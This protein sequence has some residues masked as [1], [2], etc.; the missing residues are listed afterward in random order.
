MCSSFTPDCDYDNSTTILNGDVFCTNTE[1]SC[2]LCPHKK[3]FNLS[4]EA[5]IKIRIARLCA[6]CA[7]F[8]LNIKQILFFLSSGPGVYFFEECPTSKKDV[9]EDVYCP[10]KYCFNREKCESLDNYVKTPTSIYACGKC[11]HWLFVH[12]VPRMLQEHL[13]TIK[14]TKHVFSWL[15]KRDWYPKSNCS[16]MSF[17]N[18]PNVQGKKSVCTTK[19][20]RLLE[21][22]IVQPV[23][24]KIVFT[25]QLTKRLVSTNV[26]SAKLAVTF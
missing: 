18:Q 7:I 6:S 13:K 17:F 20:K 5:I 11:G 25:F 8:L 23:E 12:K 9:I 24:M 1:C 15:K 3:L 16:L 14:Q 4:T 19:Y 10:C 22:C 21:M 26:K 2:D